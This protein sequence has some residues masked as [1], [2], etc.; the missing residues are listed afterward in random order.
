MK[1][2][3]VALA[4]ICL[5]AGCSGDTSIAGKVTLSDGAP[6]PRGVVNLNGPQGSFRGGIQPDG[7][8]AIEGV[9]AGTY[10]VAVT[11]VMDSEPAEGDGM[12]YDEEGNF[13]ESETPEPKSLVKDT[14]SDPA[15]SGLELTVPGNYDLKLDLA[16][17]DGAEDGSS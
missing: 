14:Y 12:E 15:T 4:L 9:P 13:I 11:G 6:A 5:S 17:G 7:T 16:V 2:L 10:D 8:Y 1:Y 3:L